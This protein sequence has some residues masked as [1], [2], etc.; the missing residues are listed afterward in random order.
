M[1]D[2]EMKV[3]RRKKTADPEKIEQLCSRVGSGGRP[4]WVEELL[5]HASRF[6][7]GIS[8][9]GWQWSLDLSRM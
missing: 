1:I 5:L 9:L 2:S 4:P 7:T 6:G 3:P 8:R